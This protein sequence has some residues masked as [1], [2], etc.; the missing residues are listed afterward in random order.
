M[1]SKKYLWKNVSECKKLQSLVQKGVNINATKIS[2]K[3]YDDSRIEYGDIVKE[4]VIPEDIN[5]TLD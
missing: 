4:S 3:E 5:V 2:K 1:T